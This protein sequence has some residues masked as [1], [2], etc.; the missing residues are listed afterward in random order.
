MSQNSESKITLKVI[1]N[2]PHFQYLPR[3]YQD[4]CLMQICWFQPKSVKRYHM[5]KPDFL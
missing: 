4:A 3:V 5:G 2:D 1:V